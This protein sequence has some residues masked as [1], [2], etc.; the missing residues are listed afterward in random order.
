M[1]VRGAI[2]DA[3]AHDGP[4]II[5]FIVEEE[6]RVYPMI[7]AGGTIEDLV[8]EPTKNPQEVG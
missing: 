5:D 2:E 7:K 6:E 3:M 4:V 1:Q 8:E